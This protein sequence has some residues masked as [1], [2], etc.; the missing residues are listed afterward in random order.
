MTPRDAAPYLPSRVGSRTWRGV[1]GP[2]RHGGAGSAA[3]GHDG[4]RGGPRRRVAGA[5]LRRPPRF[6]TYAGEHTRNADGESARDGHGIE[7]TATGVRVQGQWEQ[8]CFRG[9]GEME[10]STGEVH[11]GRF[12]VDG[13]TGQSVLPAGA[14]RD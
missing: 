11:R 8:G 7:R 4:R 9:H 3:A 2:S 1:G 5:G 12:E 6:I 10:M 14:E 13:V